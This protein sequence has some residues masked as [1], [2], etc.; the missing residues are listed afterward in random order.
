MGLGTYSKIQLSHG[1][2]EE[3][4]NNGKEKRNVP[5]RDG[6]CKRIPNLEAGMGGK[7]TMVNQTC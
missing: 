5:K 6:T 2:M 4:E 3:R 7:D 1:H